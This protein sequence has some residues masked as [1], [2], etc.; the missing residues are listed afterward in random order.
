MSI[1]RVTF[2]PNY[3]HYVGYDNTA[4]PSITTQ[5]YECSGGESTG[6]AYDLLDCR[7]TS[8]I[9]IDTNG[10]SMGF[11]VDL[12]LTTDITTANFCIIDNHNFHTAD[13]NLI[14]VAPTTLTLTSAYSGPLGSQL[15]AVGISGYPST[16]L[17]YPIDGILLINPASP[18]TE[19]N[20]SFEFVVHTGNFDADVT[21]GE[22][23]FGVSFSPSYSPDIDP[24]FGSSYPIILNESDAGQRYGFK[25]QGLRRYWR[26]GWDYLSEADK[27]SFETLWAVTGGGLYPFWVDLGQTSPPTLY[28]VR[29]VQDS[30]D[31]IKRTQAAYKF[32]MIL[33]EEL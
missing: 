7:R 28:Y 18:P 5:G 33:E 13:T 11:T 23:A 32:S 21:I 2:Y 19:N 27:T 22:I 3:C 14:V 10:E 25:K 20:W 8:L 1:G 17:E 15:T 31:M 29:F 26:L 9:T 24:V 12:D 30:F 16:V 6:P 4:E